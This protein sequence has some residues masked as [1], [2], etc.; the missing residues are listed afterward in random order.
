MSS[1][2]LR[3]PGVLPAGES[4]FPSQAQVVVASRGR[5]TRLDPHAERER[6]LEA[7]RLEGRTLGH[8]EGYEIGR[9]EGLEAGRREG[10]A[11]VEEQHAEALRAFT[12]ELRRAVADVGVA[13]ETWYDE[14]E[15]SLAGLA[16]EIARRALET[17]LQ[18]SPEAVV[19]I[20]KAAL[21]E[22][23]QGTRVR[24]RANPFAASALE[25]RRDEVLRAAME[26]RELEIV[27]DATIASGCVLDSD[28][29]VVDA[30]IDAF[31][32]RLADGLKERS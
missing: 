19:E 18:Q 23:R 4:V 8:A 15:R 10:L 24:I 28:G 2:V 29:G 11:Q 12:S 5:S 31:L 16:I 26:V 25:A 3:N 17:E 9:A 14:A 6:V 27:G 32:S 21:A 22:V 30:R 1:A 13:V 20:A 7:A